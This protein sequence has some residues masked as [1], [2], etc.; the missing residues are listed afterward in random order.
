M[1]RPVLRLLA[2]RDTPLSVDEVLAAVADPAAGGVVS[3]TGL[4]RD[5]D[6]GRGVSELEYVAHPD[7]AQALE[8]VAQAVADDLPVIGL[9]AVHRTGLLRVGEVAVVVAASAAHRGE[10]F[11]GARRLIDDLKAT[12]PVWKRQV[13]A[14]GDE[15]WVGTP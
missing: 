12:V 3:F 6:G 7:A 11:D 1:S 5:S 4:V 13:F 14:D 10:A 2:L 15:E 8:R 9:A